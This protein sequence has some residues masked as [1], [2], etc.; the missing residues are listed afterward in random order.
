MT[1]IFHPVSELDAL[2]D[3]A[4]LPLRLAEG[5]SAHKSGSEGK[6]FRAQAKLYQRWHLLFFVL[7]RRTCQ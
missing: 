5:A 4:D 3:I 6:Q 7:N 1:K 2:D